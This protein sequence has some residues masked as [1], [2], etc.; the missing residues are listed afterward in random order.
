MRF[1]PYFS[2]SSLDAIAFNL[3]PLLTF[4]HRSRGRRIGDPEQQIGHD[5]FIWAKDLHSRDGFTS[6]E[7][8]FVLS[9]EVA[10][11]LAVR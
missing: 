2:V 11:R 4:A 10:C 7:A 6:A 3:L 1:I 9:E 5:T 8:V